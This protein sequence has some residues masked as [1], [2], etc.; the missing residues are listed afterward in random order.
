MMKSVEMRTTHRSEDLQIENIPG[1]KLL[2]PIGEGGMAEV[3]KG[4]QI[5]LN[6]PVAIKILLRKLYE[7]RIALERFNR[8]SIIIAR[9]NN[10]NII[11]IIDRGVTEGGMP[12]FVMEYVEGRDLAKVIKHGNVTLNRKVE[13][14]IQ[15]CKAISYAHKNG[16]I[17]RDIK[18]SNVLIDR[19]GNARV[20]DFGIAQ[21]YED[22]ESPYEHTRAGILM[23]T[24]E[25]MSPEQRVSA[26]NVTK[27]SDLYS[28]GIVLYE[29]FT[30]IRPSGRFKL[31]SEIA[32][33][34]SGPL[35]DLIM[36]C[37]ETDPANR[38]SS[39]DE[40]KDRL[41]H[42]LGGAHLNRA[43]VNRAGE[44][45]TKIRQ[46]FNLLDVI[47]EEPYGSVYLYEN[48]GSG[49]LLVIKKRTS[50]SAGYVEA[51]LLTTLKHRNIVN[52]IGTSKNAR[53]FIVVMDYLNGG[54]LKDRG[55]QIY[56][57]EEFLTVARQICEGLA[58]AHKN[59]IVHG[60]LR[61]SNILFT[62]SGRVKVTDFGLNEHY[63]KAKDQRN[64]FNPTGEP[65]SVA[66]DILSAGVI[67]H[68]MLSG[69]MPRWRGDTL[70]LDGL[71]FD[72][73]E[74]VP[75]MLERMLSI[76]RRKRYG[77]FDEI[78]TE[79]D[80]ISSET[81]ISGMPEKQTVVM[82]EST[83]PDHHPDSSKTS[84]SQV[85]AAILIPLILF[86]LGLGA[87]I[88]SGTTHNLFKSLGKLLNVF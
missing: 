48:Q 79:L 24:V 82:G 45:I 43:Q 71:Y 67:F 51:K 74:R 27:S 84:R 16:V 88:I 72:L 55:A 49:N 50:S 13:F 58:F 77:S 44:G 41:L 22:N 70:N 19:E 6:R 14:A 31:P 15:I 9:L 81:S 69:S 35:E 33:G 62:K 60:N 86:L 34:I 66:A 61:P 47:K 42:I 63:A 11:H 39:A 3:Y 80:F 52:I 18:P 12:Y 17:H 7:N 40:I 23:G 1:Y 87:L 46:K 21:F 30:G 5:S 73:P 59:R 53:F 54:S 10:P 2:D 26:A 68:V 38:P 78:V 28:L 37:L 36:S 65:K 29:M 75:E 20:L 56:S 32:Q 83:R 85:A 8:E 57:L 25:Y 4:I 64:W 76:D